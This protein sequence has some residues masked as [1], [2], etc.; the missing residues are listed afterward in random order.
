MRIINSCII[1]AIALILAGC[2]SQGAVVF[3]PTPEPSDTSALPYTHPGGAFTVTIPRQWTAYIQSTPI[4]A[5]THFTPPG[6]NEP[7]A[8][9]AVINLQ[10]APSLSEFVTIINSYQTE[11]RPDASQYSEQD[12]QAMGDNIWRLTGFRITTGGSSQQVNTFIEL[13]GTFV[14]VIEVTMPDDPALFAELETAINTFKVNNEAALEPT[15]LNSLSFV[16]REELDIIHVS[17]WTTAQGVY[18]ITGEIANYGNQTIGS[19]PI[20]AELQNTDGTAIKTDT[21]TIMGYG[22]PPGGFAP[23]SLRFEEQLEEAT[24]YELILGDQNLDNNSIIY[25]SQN[26]TWTDEIEFSEEEHLLINGTLVNTGTQIIRAPLVT[27]TIFDSTQTVIAAGY[28]LIT[29]ETLIP[30]RSIDFHLRIP[31]MGGEA[32]NYI[33]DIQALPEG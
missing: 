13:S 23:F 28:T 1:F 10:D 12:R 5:A 26:M 25:G 14:S 24:N 17:T 2:G 9:F 22:I 31:E 27:V 33:I 15:T 11:I 4:L 8:G 16:R 6:N 21:S 7:M 3:E 20:Y 29:D 18:F 19:I 32:A 30:G